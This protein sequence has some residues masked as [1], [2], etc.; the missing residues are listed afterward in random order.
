MTYLGLQANVLLK[1]ND[2]SGKHYVNADN[3]SLLAV[4]DIY[5]VQ[6]CKILEEP[7]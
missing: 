2:K 3:F 7:L 4:E 6:K 5:I 1:A